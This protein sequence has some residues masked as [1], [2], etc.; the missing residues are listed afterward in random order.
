MVVGIQQ[1]ND[2][3][4]RASLSARSVKPFALIQGSLSSQKV[5]RQFPLLAGVHRVADG[6]LLGV[7]IAVAF[8]A[9]FT[10]HWQNRWTVAFARLEKSRALVHRLTESTAML[11]RY[12]LQKG[13]SPNFLVPT[14]ASNLLYLERPVLKKGSLDVPQLRELIQKPINQGY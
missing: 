13:R 9:A 8:V 14:K 4:E 5:S 2:F 12:F 7:L 3:T 1:R 6:A 10:L 11:E